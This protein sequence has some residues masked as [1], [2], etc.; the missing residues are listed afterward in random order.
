MLVISAAF[1][2]FASIH[3]SARDEKDWHRAYSAIDKMIGEAA[4]PTSSDSRWLY[5]NLER[6]VIHTLPIADLLQLIKGSQQWKREGEQGLTVSAC[7]CVAY[8]R[9]KL[10]YYGPVCRLS[11]IVSEADASVKQ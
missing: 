6:S 9:Q 1:S 4:V 2:G 3:R 7:F 8:P 5:F 10:E 11:W